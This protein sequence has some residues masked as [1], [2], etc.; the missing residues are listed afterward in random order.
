MI[1]NSQ[2][3]EENDITKK[4][5]YNMYYKDKFHPLKPLLKA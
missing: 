4:L 1:K 5:D 2:A 3:T